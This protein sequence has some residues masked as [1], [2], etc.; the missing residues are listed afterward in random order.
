MVSKETSWGNLVDRH[1]KGTTELGLVYIRTDKTGSVTG[2]YTLFGRT[3]KFVPPDSG[4]T[5]DE[6]KLVAEVE[7]ETELAFRQQFPDFSP[8]K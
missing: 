4:L 5:L 7:L 3:K 6:A 8:Y 1:L 2:V